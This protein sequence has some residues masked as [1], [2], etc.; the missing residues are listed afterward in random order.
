MDEL[1]AELE[2]PKPHWKPT[3][4]RLRPPRRPHHGRLRRATAPRL[5]ADGL[6]VTV[7]DLPAHAEPLSVLVQEIEHLGRRALALTSDVSKED[8]VRAMVEETVATLGHLDVMVANA[9]VG[10]RSVVSES[11]MDGALICIELNSLK[12]ILV[13]EITADIEDWEK[14]WEVNIRGS[15]VLQVC[16]SKAA[17]RPLTQT[18]ALE[19]REHKMTVNAYAPGVIETNMTAKEEDKI[20]GAGFFFKVSDFCTGLPT[21][22][23]A[24]VSF[25]A[26]PGSHFVTGQTAISVDDGVH[27]A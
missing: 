22:V 4:I 23:A 12:A 19:L 7:D 13:F 20:Y 16:V 11:V 18:A 1:A 27:F 8:E 17:V 6:D 15:P 10:A 14:R 21:D 2:K 26:S 5:A 3:K 24:V 9:G 25:L